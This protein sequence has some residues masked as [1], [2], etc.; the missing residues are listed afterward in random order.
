MPV[1][2]DESAARD[3]RYL[4]PALLQTEPSPSRLRPWAGIPNHRPR[5]GGPVEDRSRAT[6]AT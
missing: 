5:H 6:A 2:A 1:E 4:P 3:G